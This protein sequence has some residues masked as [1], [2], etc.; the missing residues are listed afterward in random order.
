MTTRAKRC[1][2]IAE[3]QVLARVS[4]HG[5]CKRLDTCATHLPDAV[6]KLEREAVSG[7]CTVVG[8]VR[9]FRCSH[10]TSDK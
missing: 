4:K 10:V 2:M 8:L 3:W 5:A 6:R 9:E 1:D 7:Y